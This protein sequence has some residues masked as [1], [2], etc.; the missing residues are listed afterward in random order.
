M[1]G[2]RLEARFLPSCRAA[3][4]AAPGGRRA[5]GR[6][7]RENPM[8]RRALLPILLLTCSFSWVEAGRSRCTQDGDCA[9]QQPPPDFGPG[10][11]PGLPPGGGS[12]VFYLHDQEP[13]RNSDMGPL[14]VILSTGEFQINV[15]D[16]EIPGRGFPFRLARTYR[17]RKDGEKSVLGHNWTLNLDETLTPGVFTVDGVSHPA[18]Q[19]KL[20]NG[21]A[22]VW[23]S[24]SG[25]TGFRAFQG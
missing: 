16:L 11:N 15:T 17:S 2:S 4:T 20:G 22:D 9:P 19:W 23:V 14:G 7:G 6:S 21:F 18:V 13:Y 8:I 25:E 12:P 3:E 5:A 10:L 1:G 24:Y